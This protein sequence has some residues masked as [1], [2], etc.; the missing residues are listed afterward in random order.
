MVVAI[1]SVGVVVL[2]IV[3]E[4]LCIR[5]VEV[6]CTEVV[7]ILVLGGVFVIKM[8]EKMGLVVGC[9]VRLVFWCTNERGDFL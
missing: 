5:V 1:P 9:V 4:I 2:M 6:D 8:V 7:D 3:V